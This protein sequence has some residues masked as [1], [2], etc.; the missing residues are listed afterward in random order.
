MIWA[1]T[2][3]AGLLCL[4]AA[5]AGYLSVTR[6]IAFRQALLY[7]PLKMAFLIRGDR[8]PAA[9]KGRGTIYVVSHRTRLDPA[10]MLCLLPTETLHI[11][12]RDT[13]TVWWMEPFRELAR[14]IPFNATH[15]FVSRRLVR[16]LRGN[17]SIAVYLPDDAEPDTRAFRLFRAV[18]RIALKAD[19]AIVPIRVGAPGSAVSDRSVRGGITDWPPP[20]LT[21][22]VVAPITIAELRQRPGESMITPSNALFRPGGTDAHLRH[23]AGGLDLRGRRPGRCPVR[24]RP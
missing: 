11:L 3:V 8:L 16:L 9:A 17:G 2:G 20:G 21:L 4:W 19:A 5:A 10:L 15:V 6:R 24:R 7:A 13:A 14:T 23:G 1:L 18:G 22:S 12:D